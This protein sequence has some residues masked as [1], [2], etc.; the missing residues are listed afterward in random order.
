MI[1]L[2]KP[3][4]IGDFPAIH[5]C[6]LEGRPPTIID[7]QGFNTLKWRCGWRSG[8]I[9][10]TKQPSVHQFGCHEIHPTWPLR[11]ITGS[12]VIPTSSNMSH[13]VHS[14]PYPAIIIQTTGINASHMM[15]SHSM[16]NLPPVWHRWATNLIASV[17]K[18]WAGDG[19]PLVLK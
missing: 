17:L 2:W 5:V 18:P 7:Q 1:F 11:N 12:R 16:V 13:V 19:H 9:S 6:L 15:N 3:P 10:C 4:W 14:N 8:K